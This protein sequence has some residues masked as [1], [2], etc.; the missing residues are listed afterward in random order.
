LS[1]GSA[2][3]R[4]GSKSCEPVPGDFRDWDNIE[5]TLD[6]QFKMHDLPGSPY[7]I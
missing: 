5:V 7:L 4:R 3:S 1:W 6:Q 2:D